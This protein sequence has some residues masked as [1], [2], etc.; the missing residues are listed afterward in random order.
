[1]NHI[2]TGILIA[3][4]IV[5]VKLAVADIP[6]PESLQDLLGGLFWLA[7][8]LIGAVALGAVVGLLGV[9]Q[10]FLRDRE[11]RARPGG[12]QSRQ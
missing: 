12:P 3:L 11:R 2:R 10:D 8:I 1:M 6:P 4:S 9:V 5:A 7:L